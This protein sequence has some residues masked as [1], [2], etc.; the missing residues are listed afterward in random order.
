MN[1]KRWTWGDVFR[2]NGMLFFHPSK[3]IERLREVGSG[4]QNKREKERKFC[5]WCEH[6]VENDKKAE[7]PHWK[8]NENCCGSPRYSTG[9][10]YTVFKC[11]LLS[12]QWITCM[13]CTLY[14]YSFWV[15]FVAHKSHSSGVLLS[16]YAT[17]WLN[18]KPCRITLHNIKSLLKSTKFYRKFSINSYALPIQIF[19]PPV[20]LLFPHPAYFN[21]VNSKA[22]NVATE[23]CYSVCVFRHYKR[24]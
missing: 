3:K 9:G 18:I 11:L 21:Y 13:F 24:M 10:W 8:W 14:P 7:K 20:L 2:S 15:V 5:K 6:F 17:M 23:E 19:P 1:S 22:A 16:Q 12:F 4:A